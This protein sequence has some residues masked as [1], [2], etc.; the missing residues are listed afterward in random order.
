[1]T[2]AGD[3]SGKRESEVAR[4]AAATRVASPRPRRSAWG[5]LGLWALSLATSAALWFFVNTGD[6][7]EDRTMRVRLEAKNLPPGL[8]VTNSPTES[9]E[10]RVSGPSV[11]VAGI[12]PR[13]LRGVV[14]LSSAQPPRIRE[15]L[16]ESNFSLPRKVEVKRIT[17][18]WA[19]FD[20]DRLVT[21]TVGVRLERRGEPGPG[22]RV[23]GVEIVPD[24]VEV[25]GP[26]QAVET[27]R[28]VATRAVELSALDAS[29]QVEVDL[30][31]PGGQVRV[32]PSRVLVRFDFEEVLEQRRLSGLAVRA[33]DGSGWSVQP[34]SVA[35]VVRGARE[36]LDRLAIEDGSVYVDVGSRAPGSA[37]RAR[38]RVRLPD[39]I[40]LVRVE[41]EEVTVQSVARSGGAGAGRLERRQ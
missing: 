6:G 13:R 18:A 22:Q 35:V 30:E 5:D 31:S 10:L 7:T 2:P 23:G 37:F 32:R 8:V 40:E 1:V 20:V 38:P 33:G 36:S 29:A 34:G 4:R 21:R 24:R 16:S 28:D 41:P 17:P 39:G 9:V 25:E 14:D 19:I 11:I 15:N 3:R 12:E 27:L 26:A